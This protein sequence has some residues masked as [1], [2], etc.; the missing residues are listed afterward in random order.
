MA[1]SNPKAATLDAMNS[2]RSWSTSRSVGCSR[3]CENRTTQIPSSVY[4]KLSGTATPSAIPRRCSASSAHH[5]ARSALSSDTSTLARLAPSTQLRTSTVSLSEMRL[6]H[7]TF[8]TSTP[9][10]FARI[11]AS[12]SCSIARSVS[13]TRSDSIGSRNARKRHPR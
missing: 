1:V 12:A 3:A 8:G 9:A 10:R 5:A 13:R 2:A 4:T 6:V 11:I 7:I